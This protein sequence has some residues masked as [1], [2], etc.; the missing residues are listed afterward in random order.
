MDRDQ[1][2]KRIGELKS[3]LDRNIEVM[4]NNWDNKKNVEVQTN[5]S[6]LT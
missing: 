1:N 6:F 4:K 3:F 2:S 5:E